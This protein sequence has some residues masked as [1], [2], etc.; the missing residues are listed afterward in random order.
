MSSFARETEVL[1][2]AVREAGA[3]AQGYFGGALSVEDKPDDQGPVSEAD[4]ACDA[5]LRQRFGE[6]FPDD[7]LLSEETQDDGRW[8]SARRVWI[9]DP[10]DGTQEFVEGVDQYAI[11]VGLCVDGRPALGAVYAPARALLVHGEVGAGAR[12][13][14]GDHERRL[15]VGQERIGPRWTIM[16]SRSHRSARDER[17]CDALG[18]VE[19]KP[20][21]SVGLK[22]AAI[23]QGEADCY[24]TSTSHIKLWDTCGP[25]AVIE[26]AGGV[27]LD[28]CGSQ[29]DYRTALAHPRG[30]L[31]CPAA[32]RDQILSK[33]RPIA[34]DFYGA[35][36]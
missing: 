27:L 29:L 34:A 7:A 20:R 2:A 9:I 11:M 30:L 28:L 3:I 21:G 26:A 12:V 24:V 35:E 25:Q 18:E 1:L 8:R 15:V 4:R 31:A 5:L 16:V 36:I 33:T 19:L 32:L 23:A 14:E 13:I 22:L 6:A 17:V 10:I